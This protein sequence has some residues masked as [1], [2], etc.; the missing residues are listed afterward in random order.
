MKREKGEEVREE[1]ILAFHGLCV[2]VLGR[3]RERVGVWD[4][5]V[6]RLVLAFDY[7]WFP[8]IFSSFIL[9]H[10]PATFSENRRKQKNTDN[11]DI[12]CNPPPPL[13]LHCQKRKFHLIISHPRNQK[14]TKNPRNGKDGRV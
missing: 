5:F 4:A 6:L 11:N 13:L 3:E 1:R 14:P 7:L 10:I 12:H 2:C 9:S 8:S